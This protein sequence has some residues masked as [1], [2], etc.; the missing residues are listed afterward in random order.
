[1][2]TAIC[3]KCGTENLV[4]VFS[5][6]NKWYLSDPKAISTTYGGNKVIPFAH[7]C[8]VP[9]PGDCDYREVNA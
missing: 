5:A 8:R 2:A 7:K 4:W 6:K 1:M 3:K 9:L